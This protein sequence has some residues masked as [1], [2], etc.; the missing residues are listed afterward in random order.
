MRQASRKL[1]A[2]QTT[3]FT[4]G[5]SGLMTGQTNSLGDS[6]AY[7]YDT[8]ERL[9]RVTNPDNETADYVYDAMGNLTRTSYSS[10]KPTSTK[11]GC[12][13]WQRETKGIFQL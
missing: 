10:Q 7:I 12:G 13:I 5:V 4:Y 1:G 11:T 9:T 8:A 2:P 6:R 3:D